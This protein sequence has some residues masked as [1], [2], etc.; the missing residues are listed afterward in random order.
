MSAVIRVE[1]IPQVEQERNIAQARVAVMTE[2]LVLAGRPLRDLERRQMRSLRGLRR[3]WLFRKVVPDKLAAEV[4][5]GVSAVEAALM[6]P[7]IP[8]F[9]VHGVVVVEES[10]AK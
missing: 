10:D 7:C 3:K 9:V 1:Q 6:P 2:A 8:P 5:V 4:T